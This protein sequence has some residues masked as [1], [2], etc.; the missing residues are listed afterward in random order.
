MYRYILSIINGT[1]LTLV[2]HKQNSFIKL[3]DYVG[4]CIGS[5]MPIKRET[6]VETLNYEAGIKYEL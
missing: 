5:Y 2:R 1:K 3:I 4:Q 6:H